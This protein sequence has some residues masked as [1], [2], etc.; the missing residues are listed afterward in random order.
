MVNPVINLKFNL[1]P[2]SWGQGEAGKD[3]AASE[4]HLSAPCFPV[5]PISKHFA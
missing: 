1:H 4:T 2:Q 3:E 5:I